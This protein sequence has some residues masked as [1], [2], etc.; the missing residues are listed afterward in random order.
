MSFEVVILAADSSDA[1]EL[2]IREFP[3]A[4]FWMGRV[5]K[6]DKCFGESV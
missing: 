1:E 3:H 5:S 2:S 6:G 4:V